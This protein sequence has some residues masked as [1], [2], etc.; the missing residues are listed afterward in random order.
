MTIVGACYGNLTRFEIWHYT[1]YQ[2]EI[3]MELKF[4]Q[5]LN[6]VKEL[7]QKKDRYQYEMAIIP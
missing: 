2:K 4:L 3:E 7:I 6:R 5:S 1:D